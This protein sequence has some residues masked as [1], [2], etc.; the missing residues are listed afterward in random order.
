[1]CIRDSLIHSEITRPSEITRLT[2]RCVKYR[3]LGVGGSSYVPTP[4]WLRKKRCVINVQNPPGD[5]R[6]FLWA[7]LSALY[8]ADYHVDRLSKYLP[9]QHR[10]NV[11]GLQFPLLPKNVA[12]FERQNPTIA[13]HVLSYDASTKSFI[14]VYL[15]P[16]TSREH[17]ITLLLLD[18][19]DGQPRRHYIWVKNLSALVCR[20]SKKKTKQHVCLSCLQAFSRA[21]VLEQHSR[22]CLIHAPCSTAER[23]SER[24]RSSL[25]QA[26][27][28]F[29][30]SRIPVFHISRGRFREFSVTVER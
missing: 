15:S 10:V 1:M 22:C 3:R 24:G 11:D 27:F 6:C 25:V 23:L 2:M 20:R 17:V 28:S 13:V 16:E 4:A 7:V 19:D 14:V 26:V 29:A 8:P 30:L 12:K 5:E 9:H 21:D 18:S